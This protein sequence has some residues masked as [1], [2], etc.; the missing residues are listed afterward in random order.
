M[1]II[2]YGPNLSGKSTTISKVLEGRKGVISVSYQKE[3]KLLKE[4]G[5]ILK[6]PNDEISL[7][8]IERE[9]KEK[10]GSYPIVSVDINGEYDFSME[11]W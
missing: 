1:L 7:S 4:L 9:F 5:R 8:T 2:V 11:Q 10:Y 3:T 6:I